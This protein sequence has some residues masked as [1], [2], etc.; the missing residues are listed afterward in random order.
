MPAELIAEAVRDPAES[1]KPAGTSITVSVGVST[2]T[3]ASP[4][5]SAEFSPSNSSRSWPAPEPESVTGLLPLLIR[6]L[7]SRTVRT[8]SAA[9]PEVFTRIRLVV[10]LPPEVMTTASVRGT[11][12]VFPLW[13]TRATSPCTA[14][15][16]PPLVRLYSGAAA[17]A[18][19]GAASMPAV[20][21]AARAVPTWNRCVRRVR[22][23]MAF[24]RSLSAALGCRSSTPSRSGCFAAEPRV[25]CSL[26]SA[27]LKQQETLAL[28]PE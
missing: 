28:S 23:S 16:I 18:A 20:S 21:T 4:V 25:S 22:C 8:S 6:A 17:C 27:V 15:P 11:S 7:L 26:E 1:A 10:V 3:P 12:V 14:T 19:V 9:S 13:V 2:A 24:P 5:L